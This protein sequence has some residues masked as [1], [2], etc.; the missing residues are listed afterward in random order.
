MKFFIYSTHAQ[1]YFDDL[2]DSLQ[3]FNAD[4]TIDGWGEKWIDYRQKII[5]IHKFAKSIPPNEIM[6]VIDAFD[7]LLVRDPTEFES[8]FKKTGKNIIYSNDHTF[9]YSN[10]FGKRYRQK[11]WG[12]PNTMLNAGG[13]IGYAKTYISIFHNIINKIKNVNYPIDDQKELCI[14][15]KK[16]NIVDK[17]GLDNRST[18][19]YLYMFMK[20]SQSTTT[21]PFIISAPGKQS[22]TTQILYLRNKNPEFYQNRPFKHVLTYWE[23]AF[24]RANV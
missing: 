22:L 15:Y 23:K 11:K 9:I 17:I 13:S 19:F 2:I 18:F 1:G 14:Y 10:I 16:Y 8:Q 12:C 6:S 7:S 21:N 3:L 5:A 4:Y 24:V 20:R